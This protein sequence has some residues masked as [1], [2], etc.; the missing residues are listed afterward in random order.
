MTEYIKREMKNA[1]RCSQI[2]LL[3]P[4]QESVIYLLYIM[5]LQYSWLILY[6]YDNEN[7]KPLL[8]SLEEK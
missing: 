7:I 8:T 3:K 2:R 5:V 4:F 6:G 1:R